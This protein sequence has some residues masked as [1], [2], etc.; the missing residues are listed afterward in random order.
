[1]G[2]L[3]KLLLLHVK[4]TEAEFDK[5]IKIPKNV[6]YIPTNIHYHSNIKSQGH[7]W[8]LNVLGCIVCPLHI[9]QIIWRNF[10]TFLFQ[11]VNSL[12]HK[13]FAEDLFYFYLFKV[14]AII[15]GQTISFMYKVRFHLLCYRHICFYLFSIGT[16]WLC[17]CSTKRAT[18]T[19][20]IQ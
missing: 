8:R 3:L 12:I 6:Y 17:F 9:S 7:T 4:T 5:L 2:L 19:L 18:K 13:I 1:M 10:M 15:F 20:A 14:T 11:I 16:T